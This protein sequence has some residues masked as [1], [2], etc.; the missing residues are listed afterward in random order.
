MMLSL[1]LR[2]LS[3]LC[4]P[5]RPSPHLRCRQAH[6]HWAVPSVRRDISEL[7]A[8]TGAAAIANGGDGLDNAAL[9]LSHELV[10]VCACTAVSHRLSLSPSAFSVPLAC[11]LYRLCCGRCPFP[12]EVCALVMPPMQQATQ[13]TT[14]AQLCA[15]QRPSK[16]SPF[17]IIIFFAKRS[18]RALQR[19]L[20]T[21]RPPG[22]KG[23]NAR[24]MW[25]RC[26]ALAFNG[27]GLAEG[28]QTPSPSLPLPPL[29][30]T[31]A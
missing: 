23:N 1:L 28:K 9:L 3:V 7:V 22:M 25:E 2:S 5:D 11:S 4:Q 19:P 30:L 27:S 12:W 20:N 31:S 14:S 15:H 10:C 21:N 6:V 18:G 16:R 17:Y 13:A 29:A 8:V 26:W 24:Q